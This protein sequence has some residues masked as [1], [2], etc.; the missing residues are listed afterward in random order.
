MIPYGRQAIDQ[1]DI[2]AVIE[3]LTSDYLTQGPRVKAFEDALASYLAGDAP[4]SA[5]LYAVAAN[6]AT[7]SLHLACMALDIG[8]GDLVWTCALSFAASANCA[9]Y[10]GAD[11]DFV[12]IDPATLN[13][14]IASLTD[15][16]VSAKTAGRLPKAVIPV[17]FG[18]R[19]APLAELR[20]LAT[21]YGFAIIE[22]ASHAV[23]SEYQGCKVGAHGLADITVFSF[24]PVKIITTAEGGMAVTANPVLARRIADLRS[25]GITRDTLAYEQPDEGGWYYEQQSLG[26]NYRLTDLQAALGSSQLMRIDAFIEKRQKVR[27]HYRRALSG[28]VQA[29]KLALAPEDDANCRSALHLYPVQVLHPSGRTRREVYDTMRDSGI[30]VN[31]HY[32][33]IYRHP[34]YRRMGFRPGHC[35]NAETYYQ[36]AISLPMHPGL[37]EAELTQVVQALHRALA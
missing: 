36:Q 29:G 31:V 12:D 19:S 23:G 9:R 10:C 35:P 16:L 15:K 17:D 20:A 28:L 22:D 7:S 27:D 25:H 2:A 5:P 30:G 13:I 11:V 1:A 8:P 14:S 24:H 6:S 32:I 26:Y 18:G 21:Q 4:G 34:Y 37:D 3:T 33:P